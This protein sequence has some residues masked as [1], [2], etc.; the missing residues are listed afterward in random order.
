[1]SP[2]PTPTSP[3][4]KITS[5]APMAA[6]G[7]TRP[8]RRGRPRWRLSRARK[9]RAPRRRGSASAT[10]CQPRL[11]AVRTQAILVAHDAGDR[12]AD[13][14]HVL[15]C[16]C[17]AGWTSCARASP[18]RRRVWSSES[19]AA[20]PFDAP[21]MARSRRRT[22]CGS[23]ER[24]DGDLEGQRPWP[25][26]VGRDDRRGA[27]G[28]AE[29]AR[30]DL[31]DETGG[32]KLADEAANGASRQTRSRAE[33]GT[34]QGAAVVQRA[35]DR[36]QVGATDGLTALPRSSSWSHRRWSDPRCVRRRAWTMRRA[37]IR[38]VHGRYPRGFVFLS[39]K[40][41][42]ADSTMHLP[43]SSR[44]VTDGKCLKGAWHSSPAPAAASAPPPRDCWRRMGC[45]LGL[46]SRRGENPGI[47]GAVVRRHA[48]CVTRLDQAMVDATVDRFGSSTS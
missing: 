38:S 25:I 15:R 33:L 7:V 17:G 34:R 36:A 12:H 1:M 9:R 4:I 37:R 41:R 5:S 28:R 30:A 20:R 39:L 22:D 31:G 21:A 11:G 40:C 3:E 19:C 16:R 43:L 2:P 8:A 13:A 46:A 27:A 29:R 23:G 48:T 10:S 44:E 47:D 18:D 32:G 6:R 42:P 24:V 35:H 14:E 45:K 26:A